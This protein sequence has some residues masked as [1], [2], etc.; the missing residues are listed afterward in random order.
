MANN[1]WWSSSD[2]VEVSPLFPN[3]IKCVKDMASTGW[4]ELHLRL[5][6]NGL[7]V[8][9]EETKHW[10]IASANIDAGVLFYPIVFAVL[11]TILRVVMNWALFKVK[12]CVID[13]LVLSSSSH[14]CNAL[15]SR[16][17]SLSDVIII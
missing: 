16:Q 3:P 6:W 7:G 14:V 10:I 2:Y 17:S 5:P 12:F 11:F 4:E 13:L 1:S 9:L 8:W 15:N